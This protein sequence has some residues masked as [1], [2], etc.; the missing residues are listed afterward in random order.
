MRIESIRIQPPGYKRFCDLNVCGIP[1]SARVVILIGPNGSGKSSLFDAFLL[2]SWSIRNNP[3]VQGNRNYEGYYN[4]SPDDTPHST[5]E[6][7]NRIEIKFHSRQ[8]LTRK[9]WELPR[10][11]DKYG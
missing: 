6:V 1:E 8:T 5:G 4:R 2:K 9:E 3:G 7:A 11:V 10:K